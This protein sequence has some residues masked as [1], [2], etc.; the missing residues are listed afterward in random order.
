MLFQYIVYPSIYWNYLRGYHPSNCRGINDAPALA[1]ADLGVA[2]GAGQN[3]SRCTSALGWLT[4]KCSVWVW[5]C[6][7][8]SYQQ[9]SYFQSSYSCHMSVGGQKGKISDSLYANAISDDQVLGCGWMGL[10][11]YGWGLFQVTVDAADIVLV[12]SDLRDLLV[13]RQ[14][15]PMTAVLPDGLSGSHSKLRTLNGNSI[16]GAKGLLCHGCGG[17]GGGGGWPLASTLVTHMTGLSSVPLQLLAGF[18]RSRKGNS[19][20]DLVQLLVAWSGSC[21][22][23]FPC[24]PNMF[25]CYLKVPIR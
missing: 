5:I 6:R 2:I 7:V 15:H 3:V 1:A 10:D 19:K 12:R 21:S 23:D 13:S 4:E 9:K 20:N 25:I 14:R 11:P 24:A 8:L 16:F 18:L 17:G 22:L